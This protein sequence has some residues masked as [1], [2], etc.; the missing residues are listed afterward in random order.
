MAPQ[1]WPDGR[2]PVFLSAHADELV[3]AEAAAIL[4][5]LECEASVRDVAG[6]LLRMRRVRRHRAVVRAADRAEL[7]DGLRALAT[8][9]EHP[10]VA[11]S[12]SAAR[13]PM[14]FVFPGQGNHWPGLG[15]EMYQRLP[16]YRAAADDC[17]AAFVTGGFAS[18]LPYLTSQGTPNTFSQTEI[19]AAQFTHAVAL[20]HVWRSCGI[21][22]DI[23]LGH[24]LGEVAAAQVAGAITLAD[25]GAVVA[26]RAEVV[27]GLPGRYGM[28]VLGVSATEARDL[29]AAAA[30]DG[31]W[32][33]LSVVNAATSVVVSGARDAIAAIAGSVRA[34]GRLARVIPVN[35]P[36]H[37][38]ALE[39]LRDELTSRLPRARFGEGDMRF[40]GSATAAV[41]APGTEF[42]DY[43]YANL[44]STVRF[45]RAVATVIACGAR[46]FVEM[47]A[48]PSLLVPLGDL[49]DESPNLPAGAAVLLGSGRRGQPVID[50]LSAGIAAAAVADPDYPWAELFGPTD[51]PLR[52]FPNAPMRA[53]RLWATPE[54][55]PGLAGPVVIAEEWKQRAAP[56]T[57]PAS[58][59]AV[60]ILDLGGASPLAR[61]LRAAVDRH[62]SVTGAPPAEADVVVAVAPGLDHPDVVRAAT[63]LTDLIGAGL[64]GYVDAIGPRCRDVWLVTVG[65]EQVRPG[66]PAALPAQAALGA[67]HR[68]LGLE[69]ADVAFHHLDM[70]AWDVN[71]AAAGTAVD[72]L[73]D[74]AG[75]LAL[76]ETRGGPLLYRREMSDPNGVSAPAWQ[77]GTGM[78]DNVVITGGSG[79]IGRH[80]A[81]YL[82]DR[83]ARRMVLLGR[84]GVEEAVLAALAERHGA[85]VAAPPC[86]ITDPEQVKAAAATFGGDGASLLIHAAGAAAF[87]SR[88]RLTDT[89]FADMAA[90][91]LRGL[92]G[93]AEHWPLRPD[94]R[95]LLCSSA[96]GVLG[97]KGASGYAATNRLLDVMAGQLR[98]RGVRC[99]AVRW[100]LW[101]G[102]DIVGADDI[103]HIERGGLRPMAARSAI[104]ASLFD[105]DVDPLILDA[106]PERLGM[107]LGACQGA[108]YPVNSTPHA[109]TA[110]PADATTAVRAE[111]ASVLNI[112]GAETLDIN[113][114]LFDLGIDSLLALELRKRIKRATGRTA[115]LAMLLGGITAAE[116]IAVLEATGAPQGH[117]TPHQTEESGH[118]A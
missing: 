32:L 42:V 24:S 82:A 103:A 102:T 54:P 106:D 62:R 33:E 116:L 73:V 81:R 11:R 85:E 104:E 35:Y 1:R 66:E 79:L 112:T 16:V 22:C 60:G 38:S 96:A 63:D 67:M 50:E 88:D 93:I 5:Y 4:R 110:D 15:A 47:S 71:D 87:V 57:A 43:W 2:I 89:V 21:R 105:F 13:T 18:P 70:P 114:S 49:L 75:E 44:R 59:R 48:H 76:R 99:V 56:S 14:A 39:P 55:L 72:A 41:V 98:V 8:G 95:I 10:L 29:I 91:R 23:T 118:F 94:A 27:D 34:R 77:L 109:H 53:V 90:A 107:L 17:A 74:C 65:G 69:C 7:V 80:Y 31:A 12:A 101:Q 58:Q 115:P 83:G 37:T 3:A 20:A 9:D 86:D 92:T 26:A 45:D 28:A 97:A 25:A 40:V 46:R 113:A 6:T 64:L 111:L 30:T 61:S 36:A 78:L 68:S 100:G 108:G 51:P 52:D 117:E 84:S 19:Q